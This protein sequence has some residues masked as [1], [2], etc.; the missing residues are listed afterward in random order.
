MGWWTKACRPCIAHFP[1]SPPWAYFVNKIS[2]EHS[3]IYC[4]AL[5]MAAFRGRVAA[6]TIWPTN[7]EKKITVWYFTEKFVDLGLSKRKSWIESPEAGICL[8]CS[9]CTR[10]QVGPGAEGR[11]QEKY[12]RKSERCPPCWLELVLM[13]RKTKNFLLYLSMCFKKY[14]SFMCQHYLGESMSKH[15]LKK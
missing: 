14:L 12:I 8:M 6:N 3:C 15:S 4:D 5:P 10:R 9:Q 2:L 7:P 11:K 13:P 1:L